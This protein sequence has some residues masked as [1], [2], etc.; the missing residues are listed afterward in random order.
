MLRAHGVSVM[1]KALSQDKRH[2]AM[3]AAWAVWIAG[4]VVQESLYYD[5]LQSIVLIG[6]ACALL[7]G[8]LI[9]FSYIKRYQLKDSVLAAFVLCFAV[10]GV[11][12]DNT[13]L[14]QGMFLCFCARRYKISDLISVALLVT[15][16]ISVIVVLSAL[17]GIL[18]MGEMA[19][20]RGER[21]SLGFLWPS[22]LPNIILMGLWSYLV[23]RPGKAKTQTTV[24]VLV[25]G[26][27]GLI[28]YTQTKARSPL[29]FLVL[30]VL[31]WLAFSD[32][33][34]HNNKS[35]TLIATLIPVV[36]FATIYAISSI[37]NS[38]VDWMVD[39]DRLMTNR[40]AFSHAAILNNQI[41]LFGSSQMIGVQ[42]A[43][44]ATGY[45]DSAYLRLL[46]W[47]GAIPTILFVTGL[48]ISIY[49]SIKKQ[50]IMSL[51][52]FLLASLH[53]MFEGQL[54]LAYYFPALLFMITSIDEVLAEHLG[55]GEKK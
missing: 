7:L 11:L 26:I 44:E 4:F 55:I 37:Y 5:S 40:L 9:E 3:C 27:V 2:L 8:A 39:L 16:T 20:R 15:I 6:R 29:A 50:R 13:V 33:K 47:F 35:L 38:E 19:T 17:A 46:Y 22:R 1:A 31:L 32:K 24:A 25:A 49:A 45:F 52:V 10:S 18:D 34:I 36:C 28:V 48:C 54:I 21:S 42:I 23:M 30:T 41:S 12:A 14:F 43:N 53:G 51:I